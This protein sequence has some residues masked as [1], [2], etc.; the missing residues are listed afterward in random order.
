MPKITKRIAVTY[1]PDFDGELHVDL[2]TTNSGPMTYTQVTFKITH[3][4]G[5]SDLQAMVRGCRD[6]ADQWHRSK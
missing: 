4:K 1:P 6:I 5:E 3:R 2:T